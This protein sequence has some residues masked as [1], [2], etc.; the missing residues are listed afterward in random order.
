M[1]NLHDN[2]IVSYKVELRNQKIIFNTEYCKYK[3]LKNMDI[4]FKDVLGHYFE[5]QLY[6]S[7]ILN[8]EEYRVSRFIED[9]EELLNEHKDYCWPID[10]DKIE[11]LE[12]KLAE[13]KYYYYVI[14]SSYGL[15][16][17]IVAKSCETVENN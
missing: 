11:D 7:T 14:I 13:E 5:N 17:W 1:L 9:N 15:S 4:I 16:G 8:I 2:E 3:I 12:K 6:G 10:Y